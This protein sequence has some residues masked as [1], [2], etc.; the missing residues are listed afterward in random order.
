MESTYLINTNIDSSIRNS[1][2]YNLVQKMMDDNFTK[3]IYQ[4][5][6]FALIQKLIDDCKKTNISLVIKFK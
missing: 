5:N 1:V 3:W 2:R 6:N 4:K